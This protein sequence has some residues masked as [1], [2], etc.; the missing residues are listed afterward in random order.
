M[1][2][3]SVLLASSLQLV[4]VRRFGRRESPAY[5]RTVDKSPGTEALSRRTGK[6]VKPH[7]RDRA[8][9]APLCLPRALGSQPHPHV[10]RMDNRPPPRSLTARPGLAAERPRGEAPRHRY[11]A[12]VLN[13]AP[14]FYALVGNRGRHGTTR[15][16]SGQDGQPALRFLVGRRTASAVTIL[17]LRISGRADNQLTIG[18]LYPK[19][20]R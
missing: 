14:R 6:H 3:V 15:A 10:P 12:I 1:C 18:A 4:A 13:I 2:T 7:S 11:P 17:E 16:P 9:A 19:D 8:D 5:R 20:C